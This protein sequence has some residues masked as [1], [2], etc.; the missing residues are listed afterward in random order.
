MEGCVQ[1]RPHRVLL[2]YTGSGQ[3]NHPVGL[4]CHTKQTVTDKSVNF[5]IFLWIQCF[6]MTCYHVLFI[7]YQLLQLDVSVF[8]RTFQSSLFSFPYQSAR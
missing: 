2:S 8:H 4:V 1:G 5:N 7:S 3:Q 6:F